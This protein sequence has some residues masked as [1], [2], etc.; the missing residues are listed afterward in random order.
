M[1][2][3]FQS[4]FLVEVALNSVDRWF[5]AIRVFDSYSTITL[6]RS[7]IGSKSPSNEQSVTGPVDYQ[8]ALTEVFSAFELLKA[9][10]EPSFRGVNSWLIR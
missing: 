4:Y 9:G 3:R 1:K 10:F 2:G 5:M 8:V 6:L 7:V